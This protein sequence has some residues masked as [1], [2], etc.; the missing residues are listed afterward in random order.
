MTAT[1]EVGARPTGLAFDDDTG[2]LS[3]ANS[4]DGSVSQIAASSGQV[5]RTVEVGESLRS[6]EVEE[7]L[8][9]VTVQAAPQAAET[10]PSS[11]IDALTVLQTRDPGPTDPAL[12][13][14]GDYAR[15]YATCGL[16]EN[17][18]DEPGPKESRVTTRAC[19]RTT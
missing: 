5:T 14:G 11:G 9:W 13:F 1:I 7:G 18:P 3:I 8:V 10:D 2:S 6:I 17:Y 16:L 19:D 12:F 4:L 15:A